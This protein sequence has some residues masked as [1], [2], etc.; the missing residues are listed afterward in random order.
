MD[1]QRA[2][3]GASRHLSPQ[4]SRAIAPAI[5]SVRD[6]VGRRRASHRG[7]DPHAF[8][9]RELEAV[10]RRSEHADDAPEALPPSRAEHAPQDNIRFRSSPQRRAVARRPVELE[11]GIRQTDG[12][13]GH[14]VQHRAKYGG[15]SEIVDAARRMLVEGVNPNDFSTSVGSASF[16][17]PA[18]QPTR[19]ADPHGGGDAGEQL[20][21]LADCI[22]RDLGD[23]TLWPDF[24]CRH[25][26]ESFWPTRKRDRRYGGIKSACRTIALGAK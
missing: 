9:G 22:R 25:L 15:R 20:P 16:C 10:A 26:L 8:S 3:G 19:T 17:T 5:D 6:V 1:G 23:Q 7:P 24:R 11:H 2:L 21:P 14:A 13:H 4:G 18:G 12:Q